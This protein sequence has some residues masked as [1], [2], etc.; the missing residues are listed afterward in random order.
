[1]CRLKFEA[2]QENWQLSVEERRFECRST[3]YRGGQ[4][5]MREAACNVNASTVSATT[6]KMRREVAV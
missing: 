2:F 1:M 4:G 3:D 6:K 5:I